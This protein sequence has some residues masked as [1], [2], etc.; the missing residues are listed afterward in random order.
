MIKVNCVLLG[1]LVGYCT[2]FN[3]VQAGVSRAP[4]RMETF[5]FY[6]END[7]VGNTDEHYTSALKLMW[8]SKDLNNDENGLPGPAGWLADRFPGVDRRNFLHN[9]SLSLGQNIYTPEDTQ[10]EG[11]IEDDRPYAGWTYFSLGLHAKNFNILNSVELSLG[12]VGPSSMAEETQKNLHDVTHNDKPK[13]WKN[14]LED[15]P[16]LLL[17][18]IRHW[19][20]ARIDARGWAADL[21]PHGGVTL[22][23]VYTYAN[24]GF[25]VRAGY[26][27]PVDFGTALI[28]P[29]G[30]TAAPVGLG[31]PRLNSGPFG[32]NL[33]AGLDGRAVAQN[34]FLDGNTFTDS[35]SVD[36]ENFVADIYAGFSI[37]FRQLKVTYT[38]VYRTEEFEG[39]DEGQ[40]FGSISV[41]WVF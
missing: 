35:H 24:A 10:K 6:L 7:I 38:H 17:S 5:I 2:A 25:E 28:R 9:W 16:G 40:F 11:L 4:G 27:L 1:L 29:G 32:V 21:I 31:D 36:K 37:V 20:T 18:W 34:I 22:G 13:G 41:A 23:N 15:E 3:F 33:F 14:Q 30:G 26:N 39:Q 19:R 12:L 8:I